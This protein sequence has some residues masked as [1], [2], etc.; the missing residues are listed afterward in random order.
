M[1]INIGTQAPDVVS[2]QMSR[3]WKSNV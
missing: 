3:W 1:I 2:K